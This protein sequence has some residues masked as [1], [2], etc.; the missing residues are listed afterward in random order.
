MNRNNEHQPALEGHDNTSSDLSATSNLDQL[1]D[2]DLLNRFLDRNDQTAM[3]AIITRHGPL[4]M[5]VC[6][7]NLANEHD[8]ADAFQAT[9]LVLLKKAK[10]LRQLRSLAGWLYG[11]AHRV[12]KKSRSQSMLRRQREGSELAMSPAATPIETLDPETINLIHT[13]LAGMPEKYQLPLILCYLEGLDRETVAEQLGWTIG[14]LRG[15]LERGRELLSACLKRRGVIVPA[16]LLTTAMTQ[17]ALATVPVALTTN[18]VNSIALVAAGQSIISATGSVQTASLVQGVLKTMLLSKLQIASVLI[19]SGIVASGGTAVVLQN[20]VAGNGKPAPAKVAQPEQEQVAD[21]KPVVEVALADEKNDDADEEERLKQR[22][23]VM[24][25]F[26]QLGLAFHNY[27]AATGTFT[28]AAHYGQGDKPLLSWRVLLLPYLGENEL[29]QQFKLDE[30]WDSPHN[31]KLLSKMPA[32][33]RVPAQKGKEEESTYYQVFTGK[34]TPFNGKKGMAIDAFKDGIS[35]T[36]LTIEANK[37]VPW[38]KPADLEFDADKPLPKLGGSFKDG[39][40]CGLGDGSARFIPRDTS[41][42]V[43][44]PYITPAAK[45]TTIPF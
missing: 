32:V 2:L 9:F 44:R 30:P 40:C 17:S 31:K 27:A 33:Y 34:G 7:R 4:V 22:R 16:A 24:T 25:N 28:A 18:T 35:S 36:I 13:E 19:V 12:T 26:K 42:A 14:S 5:G 23:K 21:E 41:D 37:A 3:A 1:T 8:A 43:L 38:T 6:R 15:R 11:V 45:D 39:Y 20:A 29:Y 10:S